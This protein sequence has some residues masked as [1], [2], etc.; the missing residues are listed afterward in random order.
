MPV[1][2][3]FQLREG[4][5][6]TVS[7]IIE[8]KTDVLLIPNEAI[9]SEGSQSYVQVVTASGAPEQ[10]AIQ[11]GITD[12][13]VTEVTSGLKEGEQVLIS[14]G[15]TTTST[16]TSSGPPRMGFFGPPRPRR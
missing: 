9:T 12:Y 1:P 8:E 3:D 10:R 2:E 5:T 6:V 7:I 16:T 14:Q 4:L 15:T 11:T 13:Q